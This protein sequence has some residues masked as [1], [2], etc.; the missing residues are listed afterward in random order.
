[1]HWRRFSTK[2]IPTQD[3]KAFTAWLLERWREKDDLLEHY[4]EYGDFPADAGTTPGING[5]KPL[6]GAG[7][8]ETDVRPSTPFEFLQVLIPVA[9]LALV[10]NVIM[11]FVNMVLRILHIK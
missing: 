3:E 9:A 1:M 8:I 4:V 5:T 10:I 7:I 11:K 6:Q 2:D